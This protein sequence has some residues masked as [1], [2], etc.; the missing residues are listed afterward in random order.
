MMEKEKGKS[1]YQCDFYEGWVWSIE[2][3][4]EKELS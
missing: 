1:Q 3:E 4:R 2:I